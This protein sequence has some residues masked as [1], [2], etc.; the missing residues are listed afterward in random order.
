[1]ATFKVDIQPHYKRKDGTYN[2]KIRVIHNR[3]VKYIPTPYYAKSSDLTKSLKIKNNEFLVITNNIINDYIERSNKIGH[4][5]KNMSVDELVNIL[6]HDDPETFHLDFFEFGNR[7]IDNLIALGRCGTAKLY[8]ATLNSLKK[9]TNKKTLGISDISV[10]LL[11]EYS[12]WVDETTRGE[13][14][15][16]LYLS[17]I[18]H[19]HNLAKSEYNDEEAGIILIPQSPFSRFKVPPMP[20]TKKRAL[21]VEVIRKIRDLPYR[22]RA[23]QKEGE[24]VRFNMAKDVFMLSFYLVGMNTVDLYLCEKSS[25]DRIAY[26]RKKTRSRRQ[27]KAE[28]S[29]RLEPEIL[30]L[31]EK[32][33][34]PSGERMF[35][36]YKHYSN[37]ST[38]N[39][40]VNKALKTIGEEIGVADLEFYAARHSWATIARN[41]CGISKDDIDFALNHVDP[42]KKVADIYIDKD[43]SLIDNANR[44]VIDFLNQ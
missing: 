43:W 39:Q 32:Y 14:A 11:Q 44:K 8:R 12:Q 2:I 19:L 25:G 9:F 23:W 20:L 34:D 6:A 29:I 40:N 30:P 33:K 37:P 28:I 18:R 24:Y 4:P 16:S 15:V 41:K 22:E 36:F 27:D 38:F 7:V 1:M 17:N 35:D 21:P 10:R 42:T 3:K 31:L 13:R 26:E 5:L